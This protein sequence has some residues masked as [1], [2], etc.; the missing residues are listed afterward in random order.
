MCIFASREICDIME[1]RKATEKDVERLMAIFELA[2]EFMRRTGNMTQ[3]IDG[4]PSLERVRRD[5]EE[6]NC[7]G[8]E[9]GEGRVVGTFVAAEGEEPN[10]REIRDGEWLNDRPYVT[11]HRLASDGTERGVADACLRWCMG[12]WDNVRADTH[13]DNRVLLRLL[14]AHGF[15]RCGIV[16]VENGTERIAFQWERKGNVPEG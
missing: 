8:V 2:R 13:R 6:G 11:I 9:N 16:R 15:R 12:R 1:I 3:W 4:Y 5:I 10:Y 7:Y 14:P